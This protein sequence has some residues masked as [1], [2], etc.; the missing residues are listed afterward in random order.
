[1]KKLILAV[2][3]VLII[4][5]TSCV[6]GGGQ[7]NQK[8]QAGFFT[9]IWHGWIA[10]VSLVWG[11]FDNRVRVY[12]INNNGWWYDFGFYISI[13]GGFGGF[14]LTRKKKK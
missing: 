7:Y 11:L 14:A 2:L 1:M 8:H 10:P 5:L 4:S 3:F 12:E 6:P 9:G 13:V